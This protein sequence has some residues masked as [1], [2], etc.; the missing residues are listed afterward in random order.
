[1]T[2]SIEAAATAREEATRRLAET[3]DLVAVQ[4]ERARAERVTIIA[5]LKRMR[6]NN[7]LARL[8]M[9]TVEKETGT[10]DDASGGGGGVDQ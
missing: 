2:A 3:R 7:N 6:E 4:G 5:A 10:G 1:V 9:D 8:I